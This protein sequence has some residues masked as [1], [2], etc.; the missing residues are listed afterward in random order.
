[1]TD[2]TPDGKRQAPAKASTSVRQRIREL[3]AAHGV[4]YTQ[5]AFDRLAHDHARL[6]DNDLTLDETENLITALERAG[7]ITDDEG[8]KLHGLYLRDDLGLS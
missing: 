8:W 6:S 1:M 7:V 3:A 5:T 2:T 4:A